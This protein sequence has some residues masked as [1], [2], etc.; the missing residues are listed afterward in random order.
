[1]IPTSALIAKHRLIHVLKLDRLEAEMN[2]KKKKEMTPSEF[3]EQLNKTRMLILKDMYEFVFT[4]LPN[5]ASKE[6]LVDE[7]VEE[8]TRRLN[9]QH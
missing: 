3:R 7:L 1:M 5:K 8:Y 9:H 6:R 4:C 2:Q